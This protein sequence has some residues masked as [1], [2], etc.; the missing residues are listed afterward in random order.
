MKKQPHLIS[1]R[2]DTWAKF[3]LRILEIVSLAL[4]MLRQETP[5][6]K[7]EIELNQKLCNYI[8]LAAWKLRGSNEGYDVPAII[9]ACNQ[10]H[11]ADK[12]RAPHLHK[13]PDFQWAIYDD[14]ETDRA[15]YRKIYTFEL[16][17]LGYQKG[18]ALN[19]NFITDGVIRFISV[20]HKYAVFCR[21][22]AMVGYIQN[23]N[24]DDIL[25]EVNNCAKSHSIPN[26]VLSIDGWEKRGISRLDHRLDRPPEIS[27][28]IDLRHLWIDLR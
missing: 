1:R 22:A 13:R 10:P 12:L 9:E 23:M 3:E 8:H 6:P 27:T 25:N 20:K 5:L 28:P 4:K 7:D 26:I 14:Q 16:T 2:R 15:K 24:C 18:W 11:Q 19:K 17:R 21:S